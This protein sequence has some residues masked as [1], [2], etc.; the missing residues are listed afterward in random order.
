MPTA[1]MLDLW[2]DDLVGGPV[3]SSPIGVLRQQGE[4]LGARTHNFV[5]GEVQTSDSG[6]GKRFTHFLML[7][8]P[9]LRLRRALLKVTQ[10]L[11]PY[12]ATVVETELTKEPNQNEWS[13]DVN[14]EREL[15]DCLR[16][17][18][19]EPRV[20]QFVRTVINLSNDVVGPENGNA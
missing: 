10:G 1:P 2:P 7:V 3:P 12:P 4:A 17:F 5:H 6:D 16:E 20:K 13:R 8:A 15:Q 9:F 19:N 18:F 14:N 11:E